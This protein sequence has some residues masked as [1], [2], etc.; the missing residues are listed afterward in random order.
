MSSPTQTSPATGATAASPDPTPILEVSGLT[1]RFG[2]LTALD[3]VSFAVPPGELLAILGPNGAGKSSLFNCINGVYKPQRGTV[4]IG[5]TDVTRWAPHRR[6]RAGLA[7]TFQNLALFDEMTVL[8]NLMAARSHLIRSGSIAAMLWMG[9]ARREELAH[10]EPVEHVIEFLDLGAYRN[11]RVS[12]LSYGWRKRVELGRALCMGPKVVLL[13]EPVAGM[14][15]SETE[16]IVSYLLDVK[17]RLGTTQ[18]LVEHNLGVVLDIADRVIVIDFGKVIA[19]GPPDV[20]AND[21]AVVAAYVGEKR[22][23]R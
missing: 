7:R 8:E 2:G 11:E 6:A 21:P 17:E 12:S 1:L 18:V 5:G 4:A 13:D 3:D 10:R 20:V 23:R 9:R 14:N 15:T 19:D 16:D 22:S